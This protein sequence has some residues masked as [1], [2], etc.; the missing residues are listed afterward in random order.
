VIS[1]AAVERVGEVLEAAFVAD[2]EE[3]LAKQLE[4]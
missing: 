4:G 1:E 2:M 3:E